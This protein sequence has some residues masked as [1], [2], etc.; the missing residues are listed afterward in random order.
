MSEGH[1]SRGHLSEG[2]QPLEDEGE[3]K[4]KVDWYG[5]EWTGHGDAGNP[6]TGHTGAGEVWFVS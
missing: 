4:K 5:T 2:H 3:S 1:L 6:H